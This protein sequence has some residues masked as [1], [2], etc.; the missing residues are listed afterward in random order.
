MAW[1]KSNFANLDIEKSEKLPAVADFPIGKMTKREYFD[2]QVEWVL[3]RLPQ[4]VLRL[5]EEVPLH[6]EDK[7]SRELMREMN[8]EY[9]DELCGCFSGVAIDERYELNSPVPN[10]VTI[11]RKGIFVLACDEEGNFSRT[12]LRNQIRITILHELAH[13]HGMDEDEIDDIGY[14]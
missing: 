14:G 4:K 1:M 9:D 2:K 13:F 3:K 7:P 6:V 5:L 8:V 10:S 12:E 11:F